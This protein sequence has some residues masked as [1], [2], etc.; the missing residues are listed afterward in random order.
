MPTGMDLVIFYCVESLLT[1]A[2]IASLA[3]YEHFC[4]TQ[5][6]WKISWEASQTFTS[7]LVH[8]HVY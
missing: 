5:A 8:F 3:G 7:Q 1:D 6:G 2:Q 4:Q